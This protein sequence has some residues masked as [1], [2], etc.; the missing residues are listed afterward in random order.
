MNH[1]EAHFK[2]TKE[3]YQQSLALLLAQIYIKKN[4]CF[5]DWGNDEEIVVENSEVG[6][7]ARISVLVQ[8]TDGSYSIEYWP[9]EEYRCNVSGEVFFWCNDTLEEIPATDVTA[10]DLVRTYTILYNYWKKIAQNEQ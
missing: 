1:I 3:Q 7:T 9:I 2:A 5:P 4:G 10:E 8:H 6:A